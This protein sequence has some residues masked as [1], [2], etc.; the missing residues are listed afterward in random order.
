MGVEV[1][2]DLVLVL[3]RLDDGLH[4]LRTVAAHVR[5]RRWQDA[6]RGRVGLR[7][8]GFCRDAGQLKKGKSL[9]FALHLQLL[10]EI[11]GPL[12]PVSRGRDNGEREQW[13]S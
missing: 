7:V 1:L 8:M 3:H 9:T 4:H 10:V 12:L 5:L 13:D 11:D 2:Q 6:H